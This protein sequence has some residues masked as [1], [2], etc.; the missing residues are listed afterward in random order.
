MQA[1]AL[2][3]A[4]PGKPNSHAQD[5]KKPYSDVRLSLNTKQI[6]VETSNRYMSRIKCK[7]GRKE[8]GREGRMKDRSKKKKINLDGVK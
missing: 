8:R 1:D 7:T 5:P 6:A 2:P 3:S 4:P